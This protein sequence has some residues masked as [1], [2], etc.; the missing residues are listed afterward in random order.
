MTLNKEVLF[1]Y[2]VICLIF[3][4][5]FLGYF[6]RENAVGGGPEFYNLTWPITQSFKKDFLFT[7]K[8]YASFGDGTIPFS[9]IINAYLNPFSD[10]IENFQLSTT[11]ISFVIFIIFALILKKTFMRINFIDILLTSSVFLLLPFFRTS[12][13]WG[14]NEN[15]GWLFC[16]LAFYF[17][18]EIKKNL[19]KNPKNKDILNVVFFCFTSACALYARQA[20]VF[21]PISY[22][23]YLFFNSANKKTIIIS[24][25]SYIIFAI[26]AFLL[27]FILLINNIPLQDFFTDWG[28]TSP[29]NFQDSN[30]F[31]GWLNLNHVLR[32]F[33]IL[34]GFFGFIYYQF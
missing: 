20:L 4:S 15:Y 30:F 31:G 27:I 13:F 7:I 6:L 33:P 11:I 24:I 25:I 12:A 23:L 32:N 2:V 14:K 3:I 26:P 18:S 21:L 19:S 34:L 22:L 28:T 17:F 8:N 10:V 9:H 29:Q 16:I 1:K 5:F